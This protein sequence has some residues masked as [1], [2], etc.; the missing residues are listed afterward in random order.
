MNWALK[1]EHGGDAAKSLLHCLAELEWLL[2]SVLAWQV[3]YFFR[4]THLEACDVWKGGD[5]LSGYGS[6]ENVLKIVVVKVVTLV[7]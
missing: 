7:S 3:V 4:E 5:V 2:V 6:H 1:S